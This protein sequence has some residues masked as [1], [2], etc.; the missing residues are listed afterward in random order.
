ELNHSLFFFPEQGT[1]GGFKPTNLISLPLGF[2]NS[3]ISVL[4]ENFAGLRQALN[5]GI[6]RHIPA[7]F[8]GI[9]LI[10]FIIYLCLRN[11]TQPLPLAIFLTTL[12]FAFFWDPYH[13]K[14]WTYAAIGIFLIASR[15]I[16]TRR[17]FQPRLLILLAI[18]ILPNF[19]RIIQ[20]NQPDPKWQTARKVAS[21]LNTQT[22]PGKS[23]LLFGTCE[24]DFGYLSFFYHEDRL[25]SIP[26]LI[27]KSRLDI[28]RF[29]TTID[30]LINSCRSDTG[31]VYFLNTFNQNEENLN[32]FYSRRLNFPYFITYLKELEPVVVLVYKDSLTESALYNLK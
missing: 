28:L 15:F 25:I 18:L 12:I 11:R 31:K 32:S 10:V 22:K 24:T 17:P 9:S 20:N 21:Y 19:I 16:S 27:L 29:R 13:Q 4:P 2:I 23:T 5:T 1:F 14:I 3:L 6:G 26:D 8:F 30:S 7:L